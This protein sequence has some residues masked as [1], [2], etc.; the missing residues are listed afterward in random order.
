MKTVVKFLA[1]F[2]LMGTFTVSTQAQQRANR[3]DRP[4]LN[5]QDCP[6]MM[7]GQRGP[8]H[9]RMMALLDLSD[10]QQSKIEDIHLN[11]QKEMLAFRTALQQKRAEM[12]TLSI[13][14][15]YDEEKV[16]ELA[17]EI[18]EL[19]ANMLKRRTAHQQQIKEVLNEEQRIKF[20]NFHMNR[21]P[22]I[23]KQFGGWN[24]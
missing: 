13:G 17:N 1:L 6:Q 16:A 21:G 9:T 15:N 5:R 20:D 22:K 24:R 14:D 7:A 4:G 12:R 8:Q 18:G 11:G 23:G 19:H 10:D 3:A 2:L